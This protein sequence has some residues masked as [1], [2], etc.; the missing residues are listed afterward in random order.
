MDGKA[1]G[2][3]E[4]KY[5]ADYLANNSGDYIASITVDGTPDFSHSEGTT[6]L[7]VGREEITISYG[8]DLTSETLFMHFQQY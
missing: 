2:Y 1:K 8:P 7:D 5:A 4:K 6:V 3:A